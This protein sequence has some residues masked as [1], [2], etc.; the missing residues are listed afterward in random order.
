MDNKTEWIS[1]ADL[2]YNHPTLTN[3]S[4]DVPDFG[5]KSR[6]LFFLY[7]RGSIIIICLANYI[8]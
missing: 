8:A 6:R 7:L 4:S 2:Q 3:L 5:D 1:I